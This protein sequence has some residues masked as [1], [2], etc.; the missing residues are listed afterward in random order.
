[1]PR[2]YVFKDVFHKT[3]LARGGLS[4]LFRR[5]LMWLLGDVF[6]GGSFFFQ[7]YICFFWYHRMAGESWWSSSKQWGAVWRSSE[8]PSGRT[9]RFS[10]VA[11][12]LQAKHRASTSGMIPLKAHSFWQVLLPTPLQGEPIFPE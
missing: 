4:L 8:K 5:T 12:A 3:A 11:F 1:M 9:G 10:R 6:T 2:D 7:Q